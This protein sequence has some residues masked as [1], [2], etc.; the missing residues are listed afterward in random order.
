MHADI[1]ASAD[2]SDTR[3]LLRGAGI[4]VISRSVRKEIDQG[5]ES[6]FSPLGAKVSF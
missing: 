5:E 6:R 4:D 3:L 2:F 1:N